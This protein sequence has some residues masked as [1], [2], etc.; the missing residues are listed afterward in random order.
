VSR[1]QVNLPYVRHGE[2]QIL[3]HV[4]AETRRRILKREARLRETGEWGN[5]QHLKGIEL[6]PLRI[7]A[8]SSDSWVRDVVVAHRNHVFCVLERPDESGAVHAAVTSYSNDRP[9]WYEMQR[10]KNETAVE[11]YPPQAELVDGSDTYHIWILP[12]N[13]P[14]SLA[15]LQKASLKSCALLEAK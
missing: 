12:A 4:D 15:R 6:E 11:V 1:A 7:A 2:N 13:L 10:I 9:T 3:R 14:F 8:T 5:W